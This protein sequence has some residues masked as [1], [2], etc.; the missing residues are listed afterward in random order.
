[1]KNYEINE[2]HNH[3]IPSRVVWHKKINLDAS[4]ST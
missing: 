3:R 4:R 2:T 1:M